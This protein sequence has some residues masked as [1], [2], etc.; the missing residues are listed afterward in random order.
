M[1]GQPLQKLLSPFSYKFLPTKEETWRQYQEYLLL[2]RYFG[3]FDESYSYYPDFES[4]THF[5]N[6][7]RWN[8]EIFHDILLSRFDITL[9]KRFREDFPLFHNFLPREY[10]GY[11]TA[12]SP[13]NKGK[14]TS[15]IAQE[16]IK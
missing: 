13:E 4:I 16:Y 7:L 5:Q 9:P 2:T 1:H 10:M 8:L 14:Q 6:G 3:F 11:G 15:Y 12:I